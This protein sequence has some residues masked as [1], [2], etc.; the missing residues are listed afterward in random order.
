[1]QV[2]QAKETSPV[3]CA[4]IGSSGWYFRWCMSGKQ[5]AYGI[6]MVESFYTFRLACSE[7]AKE[8]A[9]HCHQ[10]RQH[11]IWGPC[12][13]CLIS[14]RPG[15]RGEYSHV[16]ISFQC[17]WFSNIARKGMHLVLVKFSLMVIDKRFRLHVSRLTKPSKNT[18]PLKIY[19]GRSPHTLFKS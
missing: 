1:M 7:C 17:S 19:R 11:S 13:F 10:Q 6:K 16:I 2:G 15:R 8:G 4:C 9:A 14:E 18:L 3:V 5:T 12:C